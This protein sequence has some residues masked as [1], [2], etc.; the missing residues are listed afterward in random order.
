MSRFLT[1]I[2][3]NTGFVN[4]GLVETYPT[5][6]GGPTADGPRAYFG[7]APRRAEQGDILNNLLVLLVMDLN[8]N[9]M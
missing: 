5:G 3:S 9:K 1:T 7:S 8:Q 2:P 6:G 4:L